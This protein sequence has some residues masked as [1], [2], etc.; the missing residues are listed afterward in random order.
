M[1]SM[2]V[3]DVVTMTVLVVG[4]VRLCHLRVRS[5]G[6]RQ[7]SA[8]RVNCDDDDKM[9]MIMIMVVVTVGAGR[10]CHLHVRSSKSWQ[11]AAMRVLVMMVLVV[12][13]VVVV[14]GA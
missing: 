4:V 13:V 1:V 8:L 6:S 2:M 7:S 12:V 5:P 10:L 14:V 9:M 11:S 3:K